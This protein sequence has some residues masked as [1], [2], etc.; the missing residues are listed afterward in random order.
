MSVFPPLLRS[1]ADR[2]VQTDAVFEAAYDTPEAK[3]GNK[4]DPLDEA[5][6]I[7]F[8]LQSAS[9]RTRSRE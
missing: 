9:R 3:L 4:D 7:I 8:S 5:I 2:L 6:Y 1:A